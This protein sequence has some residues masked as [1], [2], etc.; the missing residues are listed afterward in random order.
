[1]TSESGIELLAI[2]HVGLRVAHRERS[3][4]FYRKLGFDEVA[5]YEG[6]R[7]SIVRNQAGVELNLIVNANDDHGGKNVLMDVDPVK[8]PGYT[9]TAFRVA[10]VR[11]TL[12]ALE[13]AGVVIS[14]G[15][16][17][18]G[19]KYLAI[20]VRDPDRNVVELGESLT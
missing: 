9:H 8:Y 5:W 14:E 18:L 6:P 15:P 20:F 17:H 7:V 1:M 16:V 12:A 11:D 13:R 4:E 10:S 3:L 19:E 2:G